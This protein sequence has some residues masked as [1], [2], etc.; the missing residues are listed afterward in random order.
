MCKLGDH[1]FNSEEFHEL[2]YK[3]KSAPSIISTKVNVEPRPPSCTK[4]MNYSTNKVV[5]A[6]STAREMRADLFDDIIL[7]D[8]MFKKMQECQTI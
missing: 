4:Y 2:N 5:P 3:M 1:C 7:P 8:L 6:N